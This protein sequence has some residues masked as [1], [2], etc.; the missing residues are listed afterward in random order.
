M[1]TKFQDYYD[2]LGVSRTAPDE[3]VRSA[4]RKL[5]RQHHPDLN[6]GDKTAE[7]RFKLINEAYEVLS[8]PE[9]RKRYDQLGQNWKAGADFTPP[10]D[11]GT[12]GNGGYYEF[13]NAD[14]R[15]FSDFFDGVFGRRGARGGAGFSMAGDDIEAEITLTLEDAHHG[16]TRTLQLQVPELCP[17]CA[18]SGILQGTVCPNC[19]GSGMV[20]RTQSLEARIP[21]GVRDGSVIRLAGK[22]HPGTNGAPAGNLLLLVRLAPHALLETIDTDDVLIELP[23]TPWEAALGAQVKVPT[24][25]EPVEMK[26]PPGSQTGQRFRLRGR[27]LNRRH[28][29]RGDEYVKLKI[30][31]PAELNETEM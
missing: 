26:I 7:E 5:A 8:D 14:S 21:A 4:Y 30:V 23:V 13:R 24:I 2:T 18:G 3:E 17:Q 11:S 15:G 12:D 9:K 27:G 6:P 29:G 22:G 28:G 20:S 31:I 10:P 1:A 19:H 25:E 16:V